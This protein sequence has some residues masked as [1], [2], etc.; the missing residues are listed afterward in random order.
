MGRLLLIISTVAVLIMLP[1][2]GS[3]AL[4]PSEEARLTV[5]HKNMTSPTLEEL[6]QKAEDAR[7]TVTPPQPNFSTPRKAQWI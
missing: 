2:L 4:K 5:V 7:Q 1:L 6:G 3:A